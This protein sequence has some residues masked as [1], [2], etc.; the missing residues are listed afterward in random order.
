MKSLVYFKPSDSGVSF[1]GIRLRKNL[2][3]ALELS[4]LPWVD[5]IYAAP[6]I[7]HLIS[8]DDD[9]LVKGFREEGAKIVVSAFYAEND[10]DARFLEKNATGG[11]A[12]RKSAQKLFSES[13]LILVPNVFCMDFVRAQGFRCPMETLLP[14][15]NLSRFEED[16][17]D[18][19]DIFYR[20]F[21]FGDGVPYC[22]SIG[23][24]DDG[25]VLKQIEQ[26]AFIVPSLRFVFFGFGKRTRVSNQTIEKLN[27][28]APSNLTYSALVEDDVFRSAVANAKALILFDGSHPDNL[29]AL[30]AM[31]AK[32]QVFAL[33]RIAFPDVL[34]DKANCYSYLE[35]SELAKS[36]ESYCRGRL[37][38]T[39][40][41]GYKTAKANS[42]AKVGIKLKA[43]YSSLFEKEK[44][45]CLMSN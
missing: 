42:L 17:S 32:V 9:N 29:I 14:G 5:S 12:L 26:I 27:R 2:K 45:S 34:E 10:P 40:I 36:L 7:V 31:A 8:P 41:G 30:E 4:S 22:L 21:R 33:G 16:D 15:V 18:E 37:K 13:D 11:F 24:V 38:P 19:R 23:D 44:A 43:C 6:E 20:Y 1:E 39:I 25:E 28:G 3:G 35:A